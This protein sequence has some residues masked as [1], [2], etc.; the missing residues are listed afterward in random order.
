MTT[1]VTAATTITSAEAA[2]TAANGVTTN[3]RRN[4]GVMTCGRRLRQ[5]FHDARLEIRRRQHAATTLDLDIDVL[6]ELDVASRV[7]LA[8]ARFGQFAVQP[9]V[10]RRREHT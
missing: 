4:H 6:P 2:P 8:N 3:S 10:H 5:R 1:A 7:T 9:R